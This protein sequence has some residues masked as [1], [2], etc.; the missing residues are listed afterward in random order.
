MTSLRYINRVHKKPNWYRSNVANSVSA[1]LISCVT[2]M[3]RCVET[4]SLYVTVKTAEGN[5]KGMVS[6]SADGDRYGDRFTVTDV[7]I[8]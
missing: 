5:R 1:Y 2:F 4:R 3:S 6:I 8:R 7:R